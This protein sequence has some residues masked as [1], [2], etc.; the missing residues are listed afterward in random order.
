MTLRSKHAGNG[1]AGV[2][3]DEADGPP[4]GGVGAVAGAKQIVASVD[5][6][7]A[8]DGAVDDG[9]DGRAAHA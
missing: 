1:G 2:H 4:N 9:Q 5:V 6:Q 8:H 3:Q 7:L